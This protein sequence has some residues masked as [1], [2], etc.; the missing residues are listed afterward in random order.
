MGELTAVARQPKQTTTTL[1]RQLQRDGLVRRV[2]DHDD[3]RAW[4]V[5][6]TERSVA[7]RTVADEVLA[8]LDARLAEHLSRTAL[9]GLKRALRGVMDL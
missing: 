9:D 1:V 5:Y 2:R 6:L 7:L 8:D 4:R 3:A